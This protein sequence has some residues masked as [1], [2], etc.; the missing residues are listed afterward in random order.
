GSRGF[1]SVL[2]S[3]LIDPTT[4]RGS[5]RAVIVGRPDSPSYRPTI[6]SRTQVGGGGRS[7]AVRSMHEPVRFR[8]A[9][10]LV[11]PADRSSRGRRDARG[12]RRARLADRTTPS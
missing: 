7:G 9:E 11:R 10:V 12:D 2:L 6:R 5:R 8:P 1:P 3:W 4:L